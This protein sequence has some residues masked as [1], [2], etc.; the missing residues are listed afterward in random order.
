MPRGIPVNDGAHSVVIAA[1]NGRVVEVVSYELDVNVRPSL[2]HGC[3]GDALNKQG[4]STNTVANSEPII[5]ELAITEDSIT[6]QLADGGT[7]SVPLT[8]SWRLSD[9]T[10]AQRNNFE[11]IGSGG[12]HWPD[13][14]EDISAKGMLDGIPA[15]PLKQPAAM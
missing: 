9:V 2:G 14:D 5:I 4:L 8:W 11:I 10:P 7:I 13:V 6:A 15:C 3:L 1:R 12:G